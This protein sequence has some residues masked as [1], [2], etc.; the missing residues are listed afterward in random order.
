MLIDIENIITKYKFAIDAETSYSVARKIILHIISNN[1]KPHYNVVVGNEII[2]FFTLLDN[3]HSN[4][5]TSESNK[6]IHRIG[7][8]FDLNVY[9]DRTNSLKE[10]E[11]IFFNEESELF[12]VKKYLRLEKMKRLIY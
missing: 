6:Y 10:N 2:M 1:K 5:Y 9:S 12:F 11:I 7:Q 8:I 4:E 3:Y